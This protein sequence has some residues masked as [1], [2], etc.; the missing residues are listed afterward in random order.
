MSVQLGSIL[1]DRKPKNQDSEKLGTA[2]KGFQSWSMNGMDKIT[3]SG[4]KHAVHN[5]LSLDKGGFMSCSGWDD[6]V[7]FNTQCSSQWDSLAHY[8]HQPTKL[9]YNGV[10]CTQAALEEAA[11]A[12]TAGN[13]LPTL[14]HWHARGC[15]VGRGVLIDFKQYADDVGIDFLATGGYRITTEELER[16]AAHQGVEF[17]PGD[18]LLVR[19]GF[20]ESVDA[21]DPDQIRGSEGIQL[22]GVHGTEDTAKWLWNKRFAAAASDSAAFEAFPPLKPD[23]SVTGM[24]GLG[25]SRIQWW[26]YLGHSC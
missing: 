17:Q 26:Q 25:K 8:H 3:A 13:A 1:S 5:F 6:E 4:R 22:S 23:G 11:A 15:L 12:K 2:Y 14:D 19:T 16:A 10:E 24:D 9:A 21:I 20:T 18:I 7:E